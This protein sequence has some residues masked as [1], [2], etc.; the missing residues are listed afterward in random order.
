[1]NTSEGYK[2]GRGT[3]ERIQ[4]FERRNRPNQNQ[5]PD[6]REEQRTAQDDRAAF[7]NAPP[8]Q[9]RLPAQAAVPSVLLPDFE[10]LNL[11]RLQGEGPTRAFFSVAVHVTGE[12]SNDPL[13]LH[14]CRLVVNRDGEP[15]TAMA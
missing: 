12:R 15:F 3:A 9:Q 8:R 10:I 1:M 13:L 4:N 11:R 6:F 14:D 7:Q 2:G 5:R